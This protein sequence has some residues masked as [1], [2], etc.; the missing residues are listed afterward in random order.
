MVFSTLQNVFLLQDIYDFLKVSPIGY[1]WNSSSQSSNQVLVCCRH[2]NGSHILLAS[3]FS[4]IAPFASS[5]N[6]AQIFACNERPH[7]FC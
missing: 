2:Q 7:V 5:K 1:S 3:E 4:C 6:S